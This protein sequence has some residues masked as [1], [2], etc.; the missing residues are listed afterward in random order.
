MLAHEA[1]ALLKH[2]MVRAPKPQLVFLAS[3]YIK[4][5][6]QASGRIYTVFGHDD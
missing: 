1:L 2:A 5:H 6:V 3:E 4:H